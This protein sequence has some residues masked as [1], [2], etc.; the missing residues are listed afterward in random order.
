ME[1]LL[2]DLEILLTFE[3]WTS[4]KG[5]MKVPL[6]ALRAILRCNKTGIRVICLSW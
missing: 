6:D 3:L 1:D 5:V 2:N 4:H